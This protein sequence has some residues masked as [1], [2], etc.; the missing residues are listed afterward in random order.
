MIRSTSQVELHQRYQ[1]V[2][3]NA[4][5][6]LSNHFQDVEI[7]IAQHSEHKWPEEQS[8]T[9][10]VKLHQCVEIDTTLYLPKYCEDVSLRLVQNHLENGPNLGAG[11]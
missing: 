2:A 10:V 8:D 9:Y 6:Y 5:A 7:H 3:A 4:A 1:Y 11:W